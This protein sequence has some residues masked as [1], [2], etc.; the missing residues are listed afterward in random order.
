MRK[1]WVFA[2]GGPTGLDL[3]QLPIVLES[4]SLRAQCGR[5]SRRDRRRLI[6]DLMV[7]EDE[8]LDSMNEK[9]EK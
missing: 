7:L 4:A 3:A 9:D 8:A 2:F 6:D 1:R 5:I